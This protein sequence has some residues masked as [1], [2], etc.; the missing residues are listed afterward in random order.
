MRFSTE[1]PLRSRSRTRFTSANGL[2]EVILS[3]IGDS[4]NFSNEK[5][6]CSDLFLV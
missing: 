2:L 4:I 5:F 1:F 3:L 6:Y